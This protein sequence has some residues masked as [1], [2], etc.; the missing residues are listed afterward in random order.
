MNNPRGLEAIKAEMETEN[1]RARAAP[2]N[3]PANP[4]TFIRRTAAFLVGRNGVK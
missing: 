1:E 2:H 4:V 3:P